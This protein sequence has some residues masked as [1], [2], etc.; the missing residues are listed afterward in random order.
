MAVDSRFRLHFG[1]AFGC[2]IAVLLCVPDFSSGESQSTQ[3]P[4]P[5]KSASAL[6]QAAIHSDY[7]NGDFD[8]VVTALEK[9]K[10][11][12][13]TYSRNDSVFIAK[14]LAV[15]YSANPVT[16]EK[17]KYYMYQ[18]LDMLPSAK[19]VDMFVSDEID[20]IFEKVREEFLVRQQSFGVQ[21][22]QLNLPRKAPVSPTAGQTLTSQP[23][24]NDPGQTTNGETKPQPKSKSNKGLWVAAGAAG[25]TVAGVVTYLILSS[26]EEPDPIVYTIR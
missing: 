11:G 2:A 18:L 26:T 13:V 1:T 23:G 22:E 4:P 10:A 3:Q 8:A 6:D 19:L 5:P 17:G 14:H 9:F 24:P 25:L 7:N 15:V 12:H 20:R 21:E 16:R